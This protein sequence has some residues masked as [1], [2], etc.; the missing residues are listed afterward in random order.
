M[1][2]DDEAAHVTL[3][4]DVSFATL[5][6]GS[7]DIAVSTID[8]SDE[9]ILRTDVDLAT[10]DQFHEAGMFHLDDDSGP[11]GWDDE[12]AV[13]LTLRL[14]APVMRM[15]E[16]FEQFLEMF[17]TDGHTAARHSE[18]WVTLEAVQQLEVPDTP[19]ATV[20]IGIRTRWADPDRDS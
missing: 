13:E 17:L 16:S 1:L 12:H 10:W 11:L 15:Y 2:D 14:R 8:A 6:S 3:D 4:Q 7:V 19:E 9:V 5:G 20:A 18:A